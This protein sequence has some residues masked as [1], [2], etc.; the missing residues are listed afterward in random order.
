MPLTDATYGKYAES[1]RTPRN[2]YGDKVY[3]FAEFRQH[4]GL[5]QPFRDADRY[6]L[7][8]GRL[9]R[10]IDLGEL[11]RQ[12]VLAEHFVPHVHD[13]IQDLG[14]E[15]A[16]LSHCYRVPRPELEDKIRDYFGEEVAWIF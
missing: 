12:N 14:C 3:A 13:Q 7:L 1:G 11:V 4:L 5:Y 2:R 9:E 15:W 10:F 6:R 16:S 8:V